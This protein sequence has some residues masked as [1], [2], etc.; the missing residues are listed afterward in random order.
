[1]P[2]LTS[3]QRVSAWEST[4][5]LNLFHY[6]QDSLRGN[7][8]QLLHRMHHSTRDGLRCVD[9]VKYVLG[10]QD[11]VWSSDRR[12][13]VWEIGNRVRIF[14]HNVGGISFEVN[15]ALSPDE[16]FHELEKFVARLY[17]EKA[18]DSRF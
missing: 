3:E 15:V 6:A 16:A 18:V 1:M 12:H 7:G 4:P 10:E 13:F 9:R 8:V 14:A 17:N 2:R 11:Y 5:V